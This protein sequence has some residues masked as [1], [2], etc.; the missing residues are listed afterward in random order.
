MDKKTL[1]Q[2]LFKRLNDALHEEPEFD[3][4]LA[5]LSQCKDNNSYIETVSLLNEIGFV[6]LMLKSARFMLLDT[7]SEN[8]GEVLMFGPL[9]DHYIGKTCEAYLGRLPDLKVRY[10]IL[11]TET[12][13]RAFSSEQANSDFQKLLEKATMDEPT[14]FSLD[15]I[16]ELLK[17]VDDDEETPPLSSTTIQ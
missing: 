12:N 6:F 4:A 5:L 2:S 13:E 9:C 3:G 15:D 10:L 16:S 1:S 8:T 14:G 7:Y 17:D 11:Q